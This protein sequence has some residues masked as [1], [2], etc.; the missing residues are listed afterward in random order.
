M[1]ELQASHLLIFGEEHKANLYLVTKFRFDKIFGHQI[2]DGGGDEE[3][4]R[5]VEGLEAQKGM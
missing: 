4:W 3:C 2:A 5:A 1:N